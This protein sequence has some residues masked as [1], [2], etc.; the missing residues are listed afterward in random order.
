MKSRAAPRCLIPARPSIG[1]VKSAVHC[2]V[3]GRGFPT[4]GSRP[5]H[6]NPAAASFVTMPSLRHWEIQAW[7]WQLRCHLYYKRQGPI[8]C[9]DGVTDSSPLQ[10][11][12]QCRRHITRVED[13]RRLL[14][15]RTFRRRFHYV[16]RGR[17]VIRNDSPKRPRNSQLRLLWH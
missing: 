11:L 4:A 15:E 8:R 5:L 3:R 10:H 1:P 12:L 2:S 16:T 13:C 17:K 14:E 7:T 9:S 6:F